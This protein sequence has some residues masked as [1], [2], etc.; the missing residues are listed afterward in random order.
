MLEKLC[1]QDK[2]WREIAFN[3]CKDSLLADDLV[4]EMYIYFSNKDYEVN[5]YYVYKKLYGLFIDHIRKQSKTVSVDSLFYL[6]DETR[7]FEPTDEEQELLEAYENLDKTQK[8]LIAEHYINEKSLRQIQKEYPL[9]NY[10]YAYRKIK[11]GK[12]IIKKRKR[13]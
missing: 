12:E 1:K 3:I 11:E 4:Q 8:E 9:I 2:T 5:N 10:G 13:K 7:V 6:Q